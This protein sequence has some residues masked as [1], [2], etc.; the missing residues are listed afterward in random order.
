MT[1]PRLRQVLVVLLLVGAL[2]IVA[3]GRP[4]MAATTPAR[5]YDCRSGDGSFRVVSKRVDRSEPS[6]NV[7]V[8]VWIKNRSKQWRGS[9][10][11]QICFYD[12]QGRVVD[13]GLWHAD[14]LVV[15]PKRSIPFYFSERPRAQWHHFT[16]SFTSKRSRLRTVDR[17]I[18]VRTHDIRIDALTGLEI[19]VRVTNRNRFPVEHVA[20]YVTIFDRRDRILSTN[21]MTYDYTDPSRLRPGRSGEF[22]ARSFHTHRGMERAVVQVEA[23]R[24]DGSERRRDVARSRT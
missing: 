10:R 2:G 18:A 16:V 17:K 15:G 4:S 1:C 9:V 23:F 12:R 22:I 24:A 11:G 21:L 6:G 20:V 3:A 7:G 13:D 8:Y 5:G 19:P 14:P